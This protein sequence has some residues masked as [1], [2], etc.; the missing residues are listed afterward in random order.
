M[1]TPATGMKLNKNTIADS[2]G[3]LPMP[4]THIPTAV[5]TVLAI[6]MNSCASSARPST[7][8]NVAR[9]PATSS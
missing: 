4:S 9:L 6:A 3:M 7:L 1:N 5:S 2:T 8:A